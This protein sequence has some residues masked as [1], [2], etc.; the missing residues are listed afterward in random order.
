MDNLYCESNVYIVHGRFVP[1]LDW[2]A[3][4]GL[5]YAPRT[6]EE[7]HK[8]VSMGNT[9]CGIAIASGA[10][11]YAVT[12]FWGATTCVDCHRVSLRERLEDAAEGFD[13]AIDHD[14]GCVVALLRE[15]ADALAARGPFNAPSSLPAL[16]ASG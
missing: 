3:E 9:A 12:S 13:Y 11:T 5:G 16:S 6:R 7:I 2:P 15:A 8:I 4:A 14:P 10:A 1:A